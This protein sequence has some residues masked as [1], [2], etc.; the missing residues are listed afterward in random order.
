MKLEQLLISVQSKIFYPVEVVLRSMVSPE[1]KTIPVWIIG[2]PRSG[3]TLAYQ[4]I[5]KSF[6]GSYLTNKVA[7]RYRIALLAR[8]WERLLN[9]N[10]IEP[11]SFE[12]KNGRTF[13]KNDP[14]EGGPL[15]YQFFPK[16]EPYT[17]SGDLSLVEQNKFKK[18]VSFITQPEELF[19]SKNTYNSLRIGAIMEVFPNS[20]FIWVNR[21]KESTISSIIKA[22]S[23]EGVKKNELWSVH[24][25]GWKSKLHLPEKELVEWQYDEIERI[26]KQDLEKTGA[27][28]CKVSYKELCLKPRKTIRDISVE[29]DLDSYLKD[30][31]GL[32]PSA[33]RY[34]EV[35]G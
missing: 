27:R 18:V 30:L 35:T 14:H 19:I 32:V 10:G 5:C 15:F 34:S 3:T 13:S 24:P 4:M 17:G 9:R 26:I 12:S 2:V 8:L 6:N 1:N 25:P 21:H 31:E 22:R 11:T 29:L 23:G 16:D 28:F 33:F 20:R 7:K